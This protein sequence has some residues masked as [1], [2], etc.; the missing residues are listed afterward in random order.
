MKY[1][2]QGWKMHELTV[3]N[4]SIN[5]WF[6]RFRSDSWIGQAS[7]N[8]FWQ[9]RIYLPLIAIHYTKYD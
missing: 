4:R 5:L 8:Y 1:W 9:F 6:N 7:G 2:H 3:W